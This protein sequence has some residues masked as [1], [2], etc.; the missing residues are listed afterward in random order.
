MSPLL[1]N[2][3]LH[4]FDVWIN[5]ITRQVFVRLARSW[6]QTPNTPGYYILL[7]ARRIRNGRLLM[8][9]P[10]RNRRSNSFS[11]INGSERPGT[12]IDYVRYADDW[13]IGV[14]GPKSLAVEI[15]DKV[16][17]FLTRELR[18]K[19]SER[20]NQDHPPSHRKR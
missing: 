12:K 7:P 9:L 11:W 20:E 13:V 17:E 10:I 19:L 5:I 3:Y 2:I 14:T 6:N 16:K 8:E 4:E 18:L 1:S 15:K